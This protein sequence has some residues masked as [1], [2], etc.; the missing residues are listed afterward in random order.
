MEAKSK[1]T[2]KPSWRKGQR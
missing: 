2:R 1:W